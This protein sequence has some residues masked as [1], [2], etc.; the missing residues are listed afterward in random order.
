[1]RNMQS[2]RKNQKKLI[3]NEWEFKKIWHPQRFDT[4]A[5]QT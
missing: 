3:Q 4:Q 1:M 2:I 5:D